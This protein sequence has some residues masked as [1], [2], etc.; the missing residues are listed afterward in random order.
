MQAQ[1][2]STE[3]TLGRRYTDVHVC[4]VQLPVENNTEKFLCCWL[5]IS[6]PISVSAQTDRRGYCPGKY[7]HVFTISSTLMLSSL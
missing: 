3:Q 6:G 5:C 2:T 1:L 4:V 7:L